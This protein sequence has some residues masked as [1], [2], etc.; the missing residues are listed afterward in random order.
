MCLNDRVK[1]SS[2]TIILISWFLFLQPR[3]PDWPLVANRF[4]DFPAQP[5][6]PLRKSVVDS[7][8]GYADLK[9]YFEEGYVVAR[10]AVSADLCESALKVCN[11]WVASHMYSNQ[12]LRSG[13]AAAAVGASGSSADGIQRYSGNA[14]ELTGAICGDCN[15]LALFYA[16]PV[17]HIVQRLLGAGDVAAPLTASVVTTFPTLQLVDSPA[18]FGDRWSISGFTSTG[19]HS[20]YSLFVGVALTDLQE[21]ERG[22]FCVHSGS[23]MT[24]IEE[25]QAQVMLLS[26]SAVSTAKYNNS[27]C[28]SLR[29]DTMRFLFIA[30]GSVLLLIAIFLVWCVRAGEA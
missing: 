14:I 12:D 23:H 9:S 21:S 27:T 1:N 25:Y 17:V 8:L 13:V 16:S 20:P 7:C 22:N 4:V 26:F 3:R 24:L 30:F 2:L 10:A 5:L 15:V 28:S 11:H 19:G 18:L 6:P 29:H